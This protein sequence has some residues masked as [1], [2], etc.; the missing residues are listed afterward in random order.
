MIKKKISTKILTRVCACG[1]CGKHTSLE[2]SG[3]RDLSIITAPALTRLGVYLQYCF[4]VRQQCRILER[5]D[6]D[7]KLCINVSL[8]KNEWHRSDS[9][10][11][12]AESWSL[13]VTNVTLC[14][15]PAFSTKLAAM[16]GHWGY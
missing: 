1:S 6:V 2:L 8:F 11:L 7:G 13:D 4:Q 15:I 12:T 9:V 10:L 14:V 5:V 3:L 16:S